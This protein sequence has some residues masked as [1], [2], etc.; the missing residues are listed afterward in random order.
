LTEELNVTPP[1]NKNPM[2][3]VLYSTEKV[4]GCN[5][6]ISLFMHNNKWRYVIGSREE[7]LY[8]KGDFLQVYTQN[9]VETLKPLAEELC[10]KAFNYL[11]DMITTLY[12][13]VYGESTQPN[14]KNYSTGEVGYRLFDISRVSLSRLD[15]SLPAIAS[16]RDNGGQEF[17]NCV[18][19][20]AFAESNYLDLVPMLNKSQP[21]VLPTGIE[22]TYNFLKRLI[23]STQ[24][25]L[26][27]EATGNP[28]G[29]IVR[30]GDRSFITKIRFEDYERHF[31]KLGQLK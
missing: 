6:R 30:N 15:D 20:E 12:F 17:F 23:D 10:S 29:I 1:A 4:D 22:E 5:S 27:K 11:E 3:S 13:E 26:S 14:F 16:W 21:V 18:F 31:R 9:I 19:L 28:E 2:Q 25:K 7:L 24:C 8:S